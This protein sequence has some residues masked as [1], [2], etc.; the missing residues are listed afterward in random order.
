MSDDWR[1]NSRT[2]GATGASTTRPR[3]S[4]AS[5]RSGVDQEAEVEAFHQAFKPEL[6][7]L[8]DEIGEPPTFR[9]GVVYDYG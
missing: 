1:L 5:R 3:S 9:W 6:E 7:M 8:A 2:C 4:R